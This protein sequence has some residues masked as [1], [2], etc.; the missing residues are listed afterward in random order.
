MVDPLEG[1]RFRKLRGMSDTPRRA[2]GLMN[3][4]SSKAVDHFT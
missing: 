1:P 3:G 2:G 4:A